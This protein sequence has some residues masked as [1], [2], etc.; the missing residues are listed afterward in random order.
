MLKAAL[1]A[2][3][4]AM[5]SAHAGA[6]VAG[7]Q[8]AG[9]S[10]TMAVGTPITSLDPHFHNQAPNNAM[11]DV[12]F[13]SLVRTD[14]RVRL[15][16]GLAESW[17]PLE[18][19]V[20]E[21]RLRPN[22]TFHNGRPF[23]A[24]DVAFT[25]ARVPQVLN[26]PGSFSGYTR[27]IQRVEV[28]DPLT[29]RLH[30]GGPYPLLPTDLANIRILNRATHESATTEEFNAGRAAIGT[31]PYRLRSYRNGDRAE[32]ER[33]DAW[34]GPK[35]PWQAVTI[36]YIASDPARTAALLA[37]DVDFI[38]QVPTGDL[39]RLRRDSRVQLS[40][41][42]G[43]RVIFLGLDRSR[44]GATP[45]ITDNDG[46]PI[47]P[48][49]LSDRRVREALSLTIDRGSI[50]ERVMEEAAVPSGQFLPEGA[51]GHVPGL[52][53]PPT[54]LAR[55]RA[56]LAEAGF[57]QG[58]RITLHGPNDR[59]VNDARIIQA[60]G[61]MWTR[62]GIRTTVEAL[63]W[64]A[65]IPRASRQDFSAFLWGWG[66]NSGEASNPLRAL[67]ATFD[68]A[69]GWGA[70]NRGRYSNAEHDR[71][72]AEGLRT[73]DDPQR[74]ALFQ[75][76]TRVAME[77]VGIVPLHIQK[78]AWAMRRGLRHVARIDEVSRPQDIAPAR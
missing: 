39:A 9:S 25:L 4:I 30:M 75:G 68:P 65:Y 31:G 16:P 33:N 34:Y 55:A 17:R 45:F 54:D 42:V 60:I 15:I 48:N 70:S 58:F 57:P 44:P 67:T 19:G 50:A 22:V 51:F 47:T 52:G 26:S 73:L 37:G 69:R 40:E 74:E 10:L 12:I 56:L 64:A 20:W 62:A 1:G 18:G 13:D 53:A 5:A 3:I 41:V 24:D 63:P 23:T 36:R 46:R 66:S 8:G 78:N 72:L 11:A 35:Q 71:L 76:A 61:Q 27:P 29:V 28:V 2:A 43:L 6:Q 49:P 14:E 38:D 7:A 32:V 21:F 59:Y 77:D